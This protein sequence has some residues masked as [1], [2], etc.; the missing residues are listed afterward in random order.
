ME[1]VQHQAQALALRAQI[2]SLKTQQSELE[3]QLQTLKTQQNELEVQLRQLGQ[4]KPIKKTSSSEPKFTI[5]T[6][7][8][9][10]F[11]VFKSATP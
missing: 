6:E 7:S 8:W 1:G 10:C 2:N 11:R 5:K 9:R 4:S 3:V